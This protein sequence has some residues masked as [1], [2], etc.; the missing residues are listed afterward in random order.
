MVL[1]VMTGIS[2]MSAAR[3]GIA[4]LFTIGAALANVLPFVVLLAL[5]SYRVRNK[6]SSKNYSFKT[7]YVLTILAMFVAILLLLIEVGFGT[8]G[9]QLAAA[10]FLFLPHLTVPVMFVSYIIGWA[11]EWFVDKPHDV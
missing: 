3:I 10:G 8:P 1:Q 5:H 9:S 6:S 2:D 4:F 7:A 11:I